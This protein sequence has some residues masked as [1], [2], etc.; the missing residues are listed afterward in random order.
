MDEKGKGNYSF[1]GGG[2]RND[3]RLLKK[4]RFSGGWFKKVH[5]KNVH[6]VE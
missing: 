1:S 6:L 4:Q 2:V 3:R 5:T